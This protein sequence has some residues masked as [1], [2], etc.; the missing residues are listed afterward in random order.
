MVLVLEKLVDEETKRKREG[1]EDVVQALV[2]WVKL[3]GEV[4]DSAHAQ[5][6]TREWAFRC[7]PGRYSSNGRET[8]IDGKKR[9]K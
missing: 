4:R 2:H 9:E 8:E 3:S 7:R 5:Q 6:Q 1:S